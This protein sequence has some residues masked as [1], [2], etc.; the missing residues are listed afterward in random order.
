MTTN[1]LRA[2]NNGEIYMPQSIEE[3]EIINKENILHYFNFADGCMF[4]R[5]YFFQI[6][7]HKFNSRD[8]F[9]KYTSLNDIKFK[10]ANGTTVGSINTLGFTN[11]KNTSYE[12]TG[13]VKV[14]YIKQ[15]DLN[16]VVKAGIMTGD[17]TFYEDWKGHIIGNTKDLQHEWH[18]F[19]GVFDTTTI[20]NTN[21]IAPWLS[22]VGSD[23]EISQNMYIEFK[24]VT[25]IP[26]NIHMPDIEVKSKIRY[27]TYDVQGQTSPGQTSLSKFC[28]VIEIKAFDSNG[29]NVALNKP[30]TTIPDKELLNG[31]AESLK[32]LNNG[33]SEIWDWI[34]FD[35]SLHPEIDNHFSFTIDLQR[36]YDIE[37]IEV[38]NYPGRIC[39]FSVKVGKNNTDMVCVFNN[40]FDGEMLAPLIINKETSTNPLPHKINIKNKLFDNS[41]EGYLAAYPEKTYSYNL[42]DLKNDLRIYIKRFTGDIKCLP[43]RNDMDF[44]INLPIITDYMIE[45]NPFNNTDKNISRF[46]FDC[47]DISAD[48][49]QNYNIE[50]SCWMFVEPGFNSYH[51]P[52]IKL[53]EYPGYN[54]ISKPYDITR[55]G[56][57]QYVKTV[58]KGF[59]SEPIN[60]ITPMIQG[61]WNEPW[62]KGKIFVTGISINKIR[63]ME[64]TTD[65]G[66]VKPEY[67][68]ISPNIIKT[69]DFSMFIEF[70]YVN[71]TNTYKCIMS[72]LGGNSNF[73]IVIYP[74]NNVE[75]RNGD[76]KFVTSTHAKRGRNKLA[77]S[78]KNN[79]MK[80][81]LN[82]AIESKS[83]NW[84]INENSRFRLFNESM[85][86]SLTDNN[87][88]FN[89]NLC[90]LVVYDDV[91]T[92]T[93]LI[94]LTNQQ[95]SFKLRENVFT[96][97]IDELFLTKNIKN[98][99]MNKAIIKY[100]PLN[101]DDKDLFSSTK[102]V[103][104]Y[105]KYNFNAGRAYIGEHSNIIYQHD[106]LTTDIIE[107]P[108]N[109]NLTDISMVFK[110]ISTIDNATVDIWFGSKT[111]KQALTTIQLKNTGLSSETM[112]K[113]VKAQGQKIFIQIKNIEAIIRDMMITPGY[114]LVPGEASH[115]H[116]GLKV[117]YKDT[118]SV[119]MDASFT[120]CYKVNV[121]KRQFHSIVEA[122]KPTGRITLFQLGSCD[123]TPKFIFLGKPGARDGYPVMLYTNM[124][125]ERVKTYEGLTHDDWV[126]NEITVLVSYNAT[127]DLFSFSILF[128]NGKKI[129][130]TVTL[131][132]KIDTNSIKDNSYE[133]TI[134]S[135]RA[136][137]Q[138]MNFTI[139]DLV[140][141]NGY[142]PLTNIKTLISPLSIGA[143]GIRAGF[144]VNEKKKI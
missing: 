66:L 136:I 121:I 116:N 97:G 94:N 92:D 33:I 43:Y 83:F 89:N 32:K 124:R 34:G 104:N 119:P 1:F 51:A 78:L 101:D 58:Y 77:F 103:S 24:D 15:S 98:L 69:N 41:S 76:N 36:E 68:V 75:I 57:W 118:M 96:Q 135:I 123:A 60:Y 127:S 130:D 72:N 52:I 120:L 79:I 26:T 134:G 111:D 140:M 17:K 35:Q 28:N 46:I 132:S 125:N 85:N 37:K 88:P 143:D 63:K 70:D 6:D 49:I 84:N 108:T 59:I 54:M 56:T 10:E 131:N 25:L 122:I 102:L 55:L 142:I 126:T 138:S 9:P 16:L 4:D 64:T 105:T 71:L 45:L 109:T 31:G 67:S 93:E 7:Y 87:S 38:Y 14:T 137:D 65:T 90:K 30:I 13:K 82:G 22:I 107:I 61:V 114:F 62:T 129:E 12:V 39:S 81:S 80:V 40:E 20:N 2:Y 128:E 95:K 117:N 73:Q 44:A 110:Y 29:D 23:D 141:I 11:F 19:Y 50:F 106:I 100:F 3:N 139:S 115:I 53:E 113:C 99:L 27:I 8:G 112:M 48:Y 133:F 74:D 42:S 86:T 21:F 144:Q 5:R 91:K 47:I 18:E